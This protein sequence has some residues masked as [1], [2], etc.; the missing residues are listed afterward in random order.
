MARFSL[1]ALNPFKSATSITR[2]HQRYESCIIAELAFID[3]GFSL[4][5][6]LREIS[7]GGGLFRPSST[8]I[9]ERRQERIVL[10][11]ER[12]QRSGTIMNTRPGGYGIKFDEFMDAAELE[13]IGGEYG[14]QPVDDLH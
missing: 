3:R 8:Y 12:V 2:A 10:N 9:L 14:L 4:D 6:A 1:Q 13:A 7:I 11:F 5:G